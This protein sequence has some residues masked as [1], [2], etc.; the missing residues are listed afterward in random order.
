[1]RPSRLAYSRPCYLDFRIISRSVTTALVARF[2]VLI[3]ALPLG[4]HSHV[5]RALGRNSFFG[6]LLLRW[7]RKEE[8]KRTVCC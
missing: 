5:P 3:Y 6:E 8:K 2:H 1:M 4:F 7:R